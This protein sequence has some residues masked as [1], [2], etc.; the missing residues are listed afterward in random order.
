[1]RASVSPTCAGEGVFNIFVKSGCFRD[2]SQTTVKYQVN[3]VDKN[4]DRRLA[5]MSNPY[6]R[7]GKLFNFFSSSS[8]PLV[9]MILR[10]ARTPYI[11]QK[12]GM[13]E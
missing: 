9:S 1:M 4:S 2:P 6:S 13:R 12:N 8:L 5:D 11:P 7:R 10:I 3:I